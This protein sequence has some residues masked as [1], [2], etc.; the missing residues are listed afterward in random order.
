MNGGN[1]EIGG[2]REDHIIRLPLELFQIVLVNQ[3]ITDSFGGFVRLQWLSWLW[4]EYDALLLHKFLD[5]LQ[6]LYAEDLNETLRAYPMIVTDR[7][8]S[9]LKSQQGLCGSAFVESVKRISKRQ[10]IIR[11]SYS[12]CDPFFFNNDGVTTAF[13][14]FLST[15]ATKYVQ[16]IGLQSAD[17]QSSRFIAANEEGKHFSFIDSIL[18]PNL[19]ALLVVSSS[20]ASNRKGVS[21][22]YLPTGNMQGHFLSKT[23][24]SCLMDSPAVPETSICPNSQKTNVDTPEVGSKHRPKEV[25]SK[26]ERFNVGDKIGVGYF[27]GFKEAHMPTCDS[28]M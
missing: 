28:E 3:L 27:I 7:A 26:A 22:R 19:E 24:E 23:V 13:V 12:P 6:D 10:L 15:P 4:I 14:H 9:P 18:D 20:I 16:L 25:I 11:H 8:P 21:Q 2:I 1:K 5:I 17:P